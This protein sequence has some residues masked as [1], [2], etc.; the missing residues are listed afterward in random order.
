[1]ATLRKAGA[2]SKLYA[3]PYTRVSKKRTKNFIKAT[4]SNKISKFNMGLKKNFDEN[5]YDFVIRIVS[6]HNV[7]IRDNALESARQT[8]LR[9]LDEKM[10]G[11]Y[12]FE[13][14]VYP[15]H[16]I[17]EN[18]MLTGAG[19]DRMQTG[20]T[21]SFGKT[22][23]RAALVKPGQE[24]YLIATS[25]DKQVKIVRDIIDIAKSKL[26]CKTKVIVEKIK[27]N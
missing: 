8:I 26:P 24:I 27:R 7:Q 2:Y 10:P 15:H 23:G 19:A 6:T 25:G 16:I 4:P 18:K 22:T 13:V 5:K 14:R 9:H 20:M 12:Y 21:Q 3:R 11:L 1:M 17:R